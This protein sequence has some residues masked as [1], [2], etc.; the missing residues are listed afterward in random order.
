MPRVSP[1]QQ[2]F[3]RLATAWR[4]ESSTRPLTRALLAM[5]HPLGASTGYMTAQ[6][7]DWAALVEKACELSTFAVELSAL[8]EDELPGLAAFLAER[9]RL[10]FHYLSVHAPTKHRRLSEA[11]LVARLGELP[12]W[13][14]AIVV[15]P[16]AMEDRAAYAPLGRRLVVE[17]M[18]PR[19]PFGQRVA[20]LAEVFAALPEAGFCLDIAHAGAVDESMRLAHDLLDAFAARLRHVHL[21]SLRAG[22]SSHV[23]LYRK[24]EHRFAPVLA[25]CA[26]VPWI[27]E[28]PPPRR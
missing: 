20:D 7:G 23:A 11:A 8:G 25:R 12:G 3:P 4:L 18:D 17:N 26:D 5:H 22:R 19:K 13:V 6:R 10:P 2:P 1:A 28:A 9:P 16:D 24:D 21:S 27:L 14:D 15:H